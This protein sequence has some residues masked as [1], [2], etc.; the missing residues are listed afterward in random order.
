MEIEEE[1]VSYKTK[2]R[3]SSKKMEAEEKGQKK[4]KVAKDEVK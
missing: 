4:E 1:K 2:C 3:K